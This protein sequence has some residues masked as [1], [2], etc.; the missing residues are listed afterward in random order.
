MITVIATVG[1]SVAI[2]DIHTGKQIR[3]EKNCPQQA[4]E[5]ELQER[6]RTTGTDLKKYCFCKQ[7]WSTA[8]SAVT[9]SSNLSLQPRGQKQTFSYSVKPR[10]QR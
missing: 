2:S 1:E 3:E 7:L 9:F 10:P 4:A 6:A 8:Q 5:Q